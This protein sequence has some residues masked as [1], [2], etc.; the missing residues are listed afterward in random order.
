LAD[1][2]HLGGDV[3]VTDMQHQPGQLQVSL[4]RTASP[5]DGTLTLVFADNPLALRQWTVIDA[6]HQDTRVTLYNVQLGGS[7]DPK[8][9]EFIDPRFLNPQG[10]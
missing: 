5:G 10:G 1:R 4:V 7:F 3:T 6:Q 8:L 9:F 2:V